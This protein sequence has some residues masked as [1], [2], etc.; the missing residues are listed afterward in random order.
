MAPVVHA[1]IR[2][3][4]I[5]IDTPSPC[6]PW[7]RATGEERES[8]VTSI[9]AAL[10]GVDYRAQHDQWMAQ[11]LAAGWT[12]GPVRS[13]ERRENPALVPYDDLPLASRRLDALL[14]SVVAAL[15]GPLGDKQEPDS[16]SNNPTD[17]AAP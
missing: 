9:H 15:L 1:A 11:R 7:N 17:G 16:S 2:A 12:W 10:S 3:Y 5:A 6:S 4:Q 8:T 14:N 13:P